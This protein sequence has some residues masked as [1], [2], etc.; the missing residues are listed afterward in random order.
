MNYEWDPDKA[1]A[2]RRKHWIRFSEAL[3]VFNDDQAL[4]MPD[5]GSEEERYV[6]IGMDGYGRVLVVVFT[7]RGDLI[8]II[9]ARKA[10]RAEERKYAEGE[11]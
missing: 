8:R 9:S 1:E 11:P 7:W 4:V 6:T 10:T 3:G 2:N 5:E